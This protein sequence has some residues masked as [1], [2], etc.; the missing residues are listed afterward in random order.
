M[1]ISFTP[2]ELDTRHGDRT[3][4]LAFNQGRLI[5]VLS[6]LDAG[7]GGQSGRWFVEAIFR[8][9]G[10]DRSQTYESPETFAARVSSER[11]GE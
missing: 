6:C 4:L 2:V 1:S 3:G 11:N 10:L 5:A 8:E 7:H 9:I